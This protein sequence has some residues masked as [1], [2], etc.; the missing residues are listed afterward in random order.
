VESENL[1][2]DIR[3][4]VATQSRFLKPKRI[5]ATTPFELAAYISASLNISVLL[6]NTI[7]VL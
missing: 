2:D 6:A 1:C 7:Q 5:V 4:S 3:C